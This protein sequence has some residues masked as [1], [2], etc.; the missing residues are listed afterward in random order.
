MIRSWCS[1]SCLSNWLCSWTILYMYSF[2]SWSFLAYSS[3]YS[4]SI[5]SLTSFSFFC[6]S[7]LSWSTILRF[8][9]FS[10]WRSYIRCSLVSWLFMKLYSYWFDLWLRSFIC[11]MQLFSL[12]ARYFLMDSS[13][14]FMNRRR[15]WSDALNWFCCTILNMA[16]LE[17]ESSS[18]H[19]NDEDVCCPW[20][21]MLSSSTN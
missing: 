11:S 8:S 10:C 3:S 2:L 4:T 13:L 19:I 12:W 17:G 6:S 15:R 16:S 14:P 21:H 5:F 20:S 1:F 18:T 9:S 7:I